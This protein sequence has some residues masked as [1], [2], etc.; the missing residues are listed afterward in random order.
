MAIRPK[1]NKWQVD[2][3][4][5]GNRAPRVSVDTREEAERV[6]ADFK[7][8]LMKGQMPSADALASRSVAQMK[9]GVGT[10]GQLAQY[11]LLH[12]WRGTKGEETAE[13]NAF[14]WVTELGEDYPVIKINPAVIDEVT[15]R[16]AEQIKPSTINRKVAALSVM[17]KIARDRGVPLPEF[18]IKQRKEYSGRLRWFSD[19]ELR[20][21]LDFLQDDPDLLDLVTIAVDTG[22]RYGELIK[23][24]P[25]DYSVAT[26]KLSTWVTK[27][28]TPRSV[29]LTPRARAV[30][31][32][33]RADIRDWEPLFPQ[34]LNSSAIS[35]RM[36]AW[37]KAAGLPDA[38]EACFHTF[39]HTCCSR[40]VQKGVP[41]PVVQKWMGH[42][43]IATTM[44]YAH[45]APNAFE[46]AV[47][48]LN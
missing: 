17:L 47:K 18:K 33:R 25:R 2:V 40:L 42:A 41:L 24:T 39:R 45:I 36:R 28:D 6:A 44:R 5:K 19:E 9:A 30:V 22:F 13:Y 37:K 16:W 23:I 4:W 26:N 20:D 10:L 29:P 3:T 12:H 46:E 34:R 43:D 31:L 8:Q 14:S 7:A 15:G 21:V 11:T 35:R 1:G 38:D 32:R 27:G 48:A